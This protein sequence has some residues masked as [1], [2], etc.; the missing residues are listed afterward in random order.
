MGQDGPGH[1]AK[2][3]GHGAEGLVG[4]LALSAFGFVL[5][6]KNRVV[7]TSRMSRQ[8]QGTAQIRRPSFGQVRLS[9]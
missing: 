2:F 1:M 5:I 3:A 4:M 8:P 6:A 7:T 9:T